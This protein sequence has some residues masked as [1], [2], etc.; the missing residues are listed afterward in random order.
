MVPV[1][2]INARELVLKTSRQVSKSTTLA[3]L[4]LSR[5]C[6]I[7][8]FNQLYISPSVDQSKIFS[9][10]RV[11][12]V[13]EDSPVLRKYYVNTGL[14]QNVFTKHLANGS[15][16][17]LRYAQSDPDRLRGLSTDIN[18]Y[19]E[20][21]DID[22]DIIP[23]VNQSMSRSMYKKSV[24]SGTPKRTKG[25]LASLWYRST[26]YEWFVKCQ[27]CYKYNF[28]DHKNIGIKGPICKYCGNYLDTK[29]G[30]WIPTGDP[31]S[32]TKGFRISIL[33]FAGAPWIDWHH[34]VIQY[35]KTCTS[36]A[37]FFNEVLG[38]EYDDG[39]SPVTEADIRR[40]CTGGPMK[41]E[42][43]RITSSHPR[44][45]GIDY[46]PM[47]SNRSHTVLT[48]LQRNRQSKPEVLFM[49]KYRAEEADY[50]FI[51]DD[52]PRQM[53]HWGGSIVGADAGLGDGPNAEIRKRLGAFEKVIAFR[54][55]SSQ[56]SLMQWNDK[57]MEYT[58][59]KTKVLTKFFQMIK[60]QEIVFP[61]WED[62]N[63]FAQDILNMTID[64]DDTMG[65]YRYVNDGPDD[66]LH[67]ILY[68]E[69]ASRFVNNYNITI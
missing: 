8:H 12:P 32:F 36:D 2:D 53:T 11:T 57:S 15:R 64:Y 20:A 33:M 58:L 44:V 1:Y 9:N 55:L 19:D 3:N 56:K 49:K 47:A 65:T 18:Y 67:S 39:V 43:D 45:L 29:Q 16:L 5:A 25:T 26:M 10:D 24:F 35:R 63:E 54:H 48:V 23:I 31:E 22:P 61:Q 13:I 42:L 60:N 14:M 69:L 7:P 17:Y 4:M 21:Q 46:G 6:M 41:T 51:H 59:N 66:A 50:G 34:D 62:F 30:Q 68:S 40:C 52:V 38:L 28:L 27:G 37:I